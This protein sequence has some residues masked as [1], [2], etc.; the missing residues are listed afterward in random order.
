M[1]QAGEAVTDLGR[2]QEAELKRLII[3]RGEKREEPVPTPKFLPET[4]DTW[5][6]RRSGF[7]HAESKY[8]RDFVEKYGGQLAIK[9]QKLM[10]GI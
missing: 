5:E 2:I 7:E 4:G 9:G 3:Q 6:Y 1:E 8:L 10:V